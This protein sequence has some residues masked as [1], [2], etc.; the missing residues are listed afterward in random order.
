MPP[1]QRKNPMMRS[2][3]KSV[4]KN[5]QLVTGPEVQYLDEED[6]QDEAAGGHRSLHA[7]IKQEDLTVF[8]INAV[9][10]NNVPNVVYDAFCTLITRIDANLI[11]Q[12]KDKQDAQRELRTLR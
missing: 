5:M 10:W 12:Q 8:K 1:K 7:G 9:D 2:T 11:N 3:T 4:N 6:K